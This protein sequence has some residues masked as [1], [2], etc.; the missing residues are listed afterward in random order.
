MPVG[1]THFR[2]AKQSIK[3]VR[4]L[5]CSLPIQVMHIGDGDLNDNQLI[6]LHSFE[7]VTTIDITRLVDDAPLWWNGG[8]DLDKYTVEERKF[9]CLEIGQK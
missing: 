6:E 5:G 2:L 8:L 3:V 7:N 4:E 9:Y 1:S